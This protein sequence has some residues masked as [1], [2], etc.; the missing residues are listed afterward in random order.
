MSTTFFTHASPVDELD[1][2]DTSIPDVVVSSSVVPVLATT[3]VVTLPDVVVTS[4]VLPSSIGGGP[5]G[6]HPTT[7]NIQAIVLTPITLNRDPGR[8]TEQARWD[9]S[10]HRDED[11]RRGR[12]HREQR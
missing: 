12:A 4:V 2:L 6:A 3:S 10:R 5:S 1:E 7:T 8:A 11:D 9:A